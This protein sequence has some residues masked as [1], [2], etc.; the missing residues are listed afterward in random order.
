MTRFPDSEYLNIAILCFSGTGNTEYIGRYLKSQFEA[1]GKSC[2]IIPL[3]ELTLK[4]R[5]LDVHAYDLIGLGYPIHA[6]YAPRIVFDFV[7]S[8]CRSETRYFLFSTVGNYLGICGSS[9]NLR[10]ALATKGWRMVH[11]AVYSM[12]ANMMF[13]LSPK[14]L[15]HRLN[16]SLRK[17][18]QSVKQI[19]KREFHQLPDNPVKR[20]MT[21]LNSLENQGLPQMSSCW[22][23]GTSCIKCGLC[24]EQCPERNITLKDDQVIFGDKC[25]F[26]LRCWWNCPQ[27]AL[28]NKYAD[29]FMLKE[30]YSLPPL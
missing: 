2:E 13:K 30:K 26:C 7:S 8:L 5:T 23:A 3:E 28:S 12:P 22:I 19:C 1:S 24:A 4:K 27:R 16:R 11:E 17:A 14:A 9:Y 10:L 20:F 6:F 15:Q 21:R 18:E 29:F 25:V